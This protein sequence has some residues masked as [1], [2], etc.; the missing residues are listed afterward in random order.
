MNPAHFVTDDDEEE[1]Q[2]GKADPECQCI[3]GAIGFAFIF[4]DEIQARKK[5]D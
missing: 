1:Q 5:T 2:N 3:D 4:H